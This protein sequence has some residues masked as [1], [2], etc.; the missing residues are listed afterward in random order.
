LYSCLGVLPPARRLLAIAAVL[1]VPSAFFDV[2]FYSEG[3]FLLASAMVLW[4]VSQPSRLTWAPL[5]VLLGSLDR[6]LGFL[7]V[8]LV[9]AALLKDPRPRAERVALGAASLVCAFAFLGVY[10]QFTGNP[11]AFAS[12]QSGWTSLRTL[13][14]AGAL[15]WLGFQ[16][17]PWTS[18]NPVILF[19]YWELLLVAV[20]L[21]YLIRRD[22]PV[23]TYAVAALAAGFVLGGVGTQSRYLAALLPLWVGALLLLHRR[24]NRIWMPMVSVAVAAGVGCNL[25]LLSRF[26]AGVWAG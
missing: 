16:L 18:T 21:L 14:A 3:L 1:A 6:P 8:I 24:A 23:A 2:A 10:W 15:Q 22:K 4:S 13:G 11:L 25:W 19:S 9:I 17:N 12:A 26:A 7:L 20:P 5:G